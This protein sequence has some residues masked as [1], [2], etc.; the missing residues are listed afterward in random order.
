MLRQR[1]AFVKLLSGFSKVAKS[2]R[3]AYNTPTFLVLDTMPERSAPV[4]NPERAIWDKNLAELER[5]LAA[6]WI[7]PRARSKEGG[8]VEDLSLVIRVISLRWVPGWLA[9]VN[10]FPRLGANPVLW[11]LALRQAVP[12][13]VQDMLER[14]NSATALLDN[15][16]LPLH[17]VIEAMGPRPG[18]PIEENDLLDTV[19]LLVDAGADPVAAHDAPYMKGDHSP[20][21]HCLWSRSIYYGRWEIA[22]AFLPAS[23]E[24]LLKLPRGLE[25]INDLH[26]ACVAGTS[27]AVNPGALRMWKDLMG[28]WLSPWLASQPE[29]LFAHPNDLV[30]LSSLS[31]QGRECVW[32]R[33]N[34]VDSLGWTGLHELALSG[35]DPRAHQ[36][37]ALAVADDAVCLAR[38]TQR[39]QGG[40]S[41]SDLWEIANERIPQTQA[42]EVQSL[43]EVAGI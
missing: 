36:A 33:W 41:P 27:P 37:L 25:M 29:E 5:A 38:W 22:R 31:P 3:L 1:A 11:T 28:Q 12:G 14:G 18:E 40:M 17:V 6:G 32:K 7:L 13:V 30:V 10:A 15:G 21:G 34:Q 39:D 43:P 42:S 8:A 23:W 19:R 16:L 24:E 26:R 4:L 9:L 20:G 35:K 2:A